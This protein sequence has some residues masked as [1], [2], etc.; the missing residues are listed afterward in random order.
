MSESPLDSWSPH[1]PSLYSFLVV[2]VWIQTL[3]QII[4]NKLGFTLGETNVSSLNT[5]KDSNILDS[6]EKSMKEQEEN[7]SQNNNINVQGNTC[8]GLWSLNFLHKGRRFMKSLKAAAHLGLWFVVIVLIYF[9]ILPISVRSA[10]LFKYNHGVLP[11][12]ESSNL[13]GNKR[14]V[15][16]PPPC[17]TV[18]SPSFWC[19]LSVCHTESSPFN[20]QKWKVGREERG[21]SLFKIKPHLWTGSEFWISWDAQICCTSETCSAGTS[22]A[23]ELLYLQHVHICPLPFNLKSSLFISVFTSDALFIIFIYPFISL[24][25]DTWYLS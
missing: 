7:R 23:A 13:T 4:G 1:S 15:S 6:G 17:F 20:T 24:L 2:R 21:C 9:I 22:E 14:S 11:A 18:T 16:W 3:L 19:H 25:Q 5:T 12:S 10:F 8:V